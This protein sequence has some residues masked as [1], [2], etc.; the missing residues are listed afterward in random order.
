MTV[1]VARGGRRSARPRELLLRLARTVLWLA[2][3][4]VLLR[5]V[6]GLFSPQSRP[7]SARVARPVP[8][9]PDEPARAHASEFAATY[10][11]VDSH[12]LVE[13]RVMLAELA[14][15][16][17]LE[18][19][20]PT[21]D[22]NVLRQVVASTTVE[23]AFALDPEHALVTVAAR[24]TGSKGSRT[25]RLVVPVARDKRGGLVVNDLPSLAPA[26][27]QAKA[28]SP[29]GDSLLG[30][31]R[32]AIEEVL[33]RFLRAFVSGD[34]EGLVYLSPPGTTIEAV[35]GGFELVDLGSLTSLGPENARQR[36]VLAV[37]RV[38][39]RQSGATYALR[40]RVQLVRL[41]RWYVA[42]LNGS[43]EG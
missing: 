37:A 8:A 4:V 2:V 38:R 43:Q 42:A 10:L 26:P 13:Q 35:R 40:Y 16:E 32:D 3:L 5:G 27:R 19:L 7:A 24:V 9:W 15:P 11:T 18:A 34:R 14:T 1:L 23:R 41:D 29:A 22:G 28:G 25:L 39:D 31:D 33:T 6:A 36:L 12:R 20:L 17:V 30:D 21:L